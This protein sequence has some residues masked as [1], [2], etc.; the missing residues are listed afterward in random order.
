MNISERQKHCLKLIV[1][2]YISSGQPVASNFLIE[3]AGLNMSSATLRAEMNH[4]E[5]EGYLQKAHTSSGR[6]PTTLGYEFYAKNHDRKEDEHLGRVLKDIFAQRRASI[7]I[8]LDEAAN[9]ISDIAG[10]TVITSS[11]ETNELMKSIQL[12]PLNER[13]A[14]IVIVTSTGRVESKLIEINNHIKIEDVRIAVRLFKERLVDTPLNELSIKIDTLAPILADSIKNYEDLMQTFATKVFDFH[15]KISSKVYGDTNIIKS[16]HLT[17]ED[18]VKLMM[19]LKSKSI[20]ET[21]EDKLDEDEKIKIDIRP[22]NTSIISKRINIQN[23]SKDIAIVG[24]NR[25]DYAEAKF[26]IELLS[27]LLKG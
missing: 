26:V 21:I 25:I 24:S 2:E 6:I 10:L 23:V 5:V 17:R 1:E 9:A 12:T 7:D 20:F 4:L 22:D 27:N 8:T 11:S 13:S 3:K 18:L 15:N 16:D 14:T 19:L